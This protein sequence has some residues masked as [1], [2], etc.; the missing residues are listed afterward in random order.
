MSIKELLQQ[1][2]KAY[3]EAGD[4]ERKGFAELAENEMPQV[5]SAIYTPGFAAGKAEGGKKKADVTARITALETE[6]AELKKENEEL[7]R[8]APDVAE[9]KKTHAKQLAD[10]EEKHKAEIAKRDAAERQMSFKTTLKDVE[11]ALV[12]AGL[13]PD[14]ARARVVLLRE[15]GFIKQNEDG[16]IQ[17]MRLDNPDVPY[18][19][20]TNRANKPYESLVRDV[21]QKADPLDILAGGDRGGGVGGQG[22]GEMKPDV[23]KIQEQKAARGDYVAI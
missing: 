16:T 7:T 19:E 6:N 8:K 2:A 5:H 20:P 3:A 18:S 17:Y 15:D 1:L 22:G 12:D 21:R 11:K 9:L 14:A 4:D 10:Q 13:R 23:K